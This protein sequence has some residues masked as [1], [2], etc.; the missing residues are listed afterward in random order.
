MADFAEARAAL[1]NA[2]LPKDSPRLKE[3]Q[4]A[5]LER[6]GQR[7]D[8]RKLF[9]GHLMFKDGAAQRRLRRLVSTAFTQRRVDKLRPRVE[10]LVDATMDRLHLDGPVDVVA[11]VAFPCRWR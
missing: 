11:E 8:L 1:P 3:L 5:H 9:D 4:R 10:H 6:A 2:R 7:E